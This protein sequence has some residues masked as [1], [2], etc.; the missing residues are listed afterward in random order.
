MKSHILG[1][2]K[3]EIADTSA[4]KKTKKKKYLQWEM[5]FFYREEKGRLNRRG[6]SVT[7]MIR[8]KKNSDEGNGIC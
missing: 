6:A 2:K 4:K 1:Q 7:P 5:Y 3:N 8:G